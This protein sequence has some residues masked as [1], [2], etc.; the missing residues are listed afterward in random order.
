MR[1][2]PSRAQ[3]W[4]P[5][6]GTPARMGFRLPSAMSPSQI[7]PPDLSLLLVENLSPSPVQSTA[8]DEPGQRRDLT[9]APSSRPED[10][11]PALGLVRRGFGLPERN[12]DVRA[13]RRNRYPPGLRSVEKKRY[14]H[15]EL[16]FA[17]GDRQGR[18]PESL[19][20]LQRGVHRPLRPGRAV[21]HG[22]DDQEMLARFELEVGGHGLARGRLAQSPLRPPPWPSCSWRRPAGRQDRPGTAAPKPTRSGRARIVRRR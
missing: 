1:N 21:V 17:D 19:F 2:E 14:G 3:V 15:P 22:P 4:R 16:V 12:R 13:V 18:G 7:V 5:S 6:L 8:P 10:L 20:R 11:G 9:D